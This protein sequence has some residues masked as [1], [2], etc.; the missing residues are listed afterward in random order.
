MLLVVKMRL[1][2][3]GGPSGG[4][5]LSA[6]ARGSRLREVGGSSLGAQHLPSRGSGLARVGDRVQAA[7]METF[8]FVPRI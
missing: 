3:W 8:R 4:I 5:Y 7:G 6:P 1:P 2:C